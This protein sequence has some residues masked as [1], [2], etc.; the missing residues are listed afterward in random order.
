[1]DKK[2]PTQEIK[3]YSNGR[4]KYIKNGTKK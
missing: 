1:M 2:G 3:Y 4:K